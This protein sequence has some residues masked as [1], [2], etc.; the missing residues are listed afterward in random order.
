MGLDVEEGGGKE[1]TKNDSGIIT[2]A[3]GAWECHLQ[4]YEV[5]SKGSI[6]MLG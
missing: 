3:W 4:A 2:S 5:K 1:G 6:R